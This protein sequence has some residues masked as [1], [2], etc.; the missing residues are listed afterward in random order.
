MS[1]KLNMNDVNVSNNE[2]NG[3]LSQGMCNFPLKKRAN[4][5]TILEDEI[6]MF[7]QFL[8]TSHV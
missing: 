7:L 5:A 3:W 2:C 8:G 1:P 6:D 4:S